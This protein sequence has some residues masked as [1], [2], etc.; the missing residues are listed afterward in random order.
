M[1]L[2]LKTMITAISVPLLLTACVGNS[3]EVSVIT[4]KDMQHHNWELVQIDGTNV[5]LGSEN[6][7]VRLEIGENMTANGHAGCN[8]FFGQ[9]ELK[10]NQFRIDKMGMTMKMCDEA[11]MN[12]EM[13]MS[14]V[15][16]D[17]SEI[18]LSNDSLELKNDTHTL[19]FVLRDWVN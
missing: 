9:G 19:T 16:T 18:T 11:S 8:N 1:K 4:A 10:D 7:P 6:K 14:H 12:N 5:V 17:W 13:V 3:E 2:S 15:L